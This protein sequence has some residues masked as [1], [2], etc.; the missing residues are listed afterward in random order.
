MQIQETLKLFQWFL[1]GNVKKWV[2]PF[3]GVG[4]TQDFLLY[5]KSEFMNLADFLHADC[6]AVIFG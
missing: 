6:E 4:E 3:M 2:W 5:L 1:G